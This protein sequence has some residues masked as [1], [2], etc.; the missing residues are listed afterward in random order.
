ME[1]LQQKPPETKK[2]IE[3][4]EAEDSPEQQQDPEQFRNSLKIFDR[5]VQV[6]AEQ[7]KQPEYTMRFDKEEQGLVVGL[8]GT[9]NVFLAEAAQQDNTVSIAKMF[10][11]LEGAI[12]DQNETTDEATLDKLKLVATKMRYNLQVRH[13][14]RNKNKK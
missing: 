4:Q 11:R 12:R 13:D 8:R 3:D 10:D 9:L 5:Y 2:S 7:A 1:T 6:N 14:K